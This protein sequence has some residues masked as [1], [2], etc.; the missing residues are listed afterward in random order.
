M[1]EFLKTVD[2]WFLIL[3]VVILAGALMLSAKVM[4]NAFMK[5]LENSFEVLNNTMKAF[6]ETI[7]RLFDKHENHERRISQLEGAHAVNHGLDLNFNRRSTDP[8]EI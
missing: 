5:H 4:F 6:E 2:T 7:K 8:S 3:A 1:A